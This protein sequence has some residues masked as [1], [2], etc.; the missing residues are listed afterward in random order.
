MNFSVASPG[1]TAMQQNGKSP[2]GY[3]KK[4]SYSLPI[5]SPVAS[6]KQTSHSL[7][8]EHNTVVPEESILV[9]NLFVHSKKGI[10][11]PM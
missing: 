3:A 6:G 4:P 1:R 8:P 5:H 11:S 10:L 9:L 2:A 7:V